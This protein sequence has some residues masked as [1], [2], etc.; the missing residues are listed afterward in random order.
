MTWWVQY[1]RTTTGGSREQL[2]VHGPPVWVRILWTRRTCPT[3]LAISTSEINPT[4]CRPGRTSELIWISIISL[5]APDCRTVSDWRGRLIRIWQ[6]WKVSSP[7]SPGPEQAS[8]SVTSHLR[9]A[10][11]IPDR[12]VEWKQPLNSGAAFKSVQDKPENIARGI[13]FLPPSPSLS[14]SRAGK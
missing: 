12:S 2:L 1:P 10:V 4:T 6:T 14:I 3:L 7:G 8:Y 5:L 11:H 13:I 9:I